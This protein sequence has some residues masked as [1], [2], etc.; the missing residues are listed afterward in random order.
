MIFPARLVVVAAVVAVAVSATPGTPV[1]RLPDGHP[2]LQ[3]VW[4]NSTLT[5]L[6]RPLT[7]GDRAFGDPR[8]QWTAF[9]L[10]L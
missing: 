9:R 3:A 2:D 5:P 6:E 8:I 1:P 7:L 4:E 10:G